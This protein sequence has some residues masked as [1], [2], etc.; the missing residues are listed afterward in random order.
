MTQPPPAPGWYPDPSGQGQRYWD[1]S[2]WGPAAPTDSPGSASGKKK[3]R[4]IWVAGAVVLLIIIVG[5]LN[6]KNDKSGTT[7]STPAAP[8]SSPMQTASPSQGSEAAPKTAAGGTVTYEVESD[9]SLSTVTYFDELNNEKQVTDVASPW[10]MTFTSQ[11]TYPIY[12]LGAQTSGEHVS[13]K[14]SVDGKVRD[15]KSA[16][17]RYAVVNCNA[18]PS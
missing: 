1:G 3:R 6:G 10:N 12:G 13:C 11:A 4:W 9:G 18:S 14:I 8:P 7:G 17:G 2:T 16:T 15:Q 5:A